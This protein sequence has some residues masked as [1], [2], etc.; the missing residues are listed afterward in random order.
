MLSRRLLL[1]TSA[2]TPFLSYAALADTPKDVVIVG[3]AIDDIISLDPHESFEFS[4]GEVVNN[5][6]DRLVTPDP[7]EPSKVIGELA[8]TWT[9]SPDG[10]VFTFTLRAGPRFASGKPITAE[11]A[12]FTLQRAVKLNKTPAFIINQFG[13]TKDN[14]DQKIVVTGPSTFTLT[15]AA[16]QSP[17]FFLYCLSANVGSIVEKAVVMSHA[18]GDDLGNG[19]LKTNSAGSGP[20]VVRSWKAS[21][22]VLLDANTNAN[23]PPK[24]KRVIIKHMADPQAQLLQLQQGDIDIARDLLPDQIKAAQKDPSMVVSSALRSTIMYLAMNQKDPNLAKPQVRQALKWAVD[25]QGIQ[26]NIVPTTW[27]VQQSFVPQGF[28]GAIKDQP[29]KMDAA[30]AKA[31]LAEAGLPNGFEVTLDHSS[32][33]PIPDIAQA[34]QANLAAIGIK[35]TLLAGEQRQVIT[36][37]RAR[38]HQL[39]LL[40]WG[41]DYFDPHSNAETFSMNQD[42]ADDARNKTL[43]WRNAWKDDDLT[44]RTLAAVKEADTKTREAMYVAIQR[45]HHARS[46]FVIMLQNTEKAVMRKAVA[47]FAL[48]PV[49]ARTLYAGISKT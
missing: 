44:A 17:T 32:V 8:E 16:K 42:N 48:A 30:K 39:T 40:S 13:F 49:Y 35:V 2:S 31:L 36:K 46:P 29:F 15:I 3:K 21:E 22:S 1:A 9:V 45:D 7:E 27:E 23:K 41:S 18:Q 34:I 28:L 33:Q 4:G 37:Y 47:G 10:L 6:Y 14:A 12:A 19:W 11:D 25:Y 20:F 5:C 38:Q 43:S 24:P 26:A